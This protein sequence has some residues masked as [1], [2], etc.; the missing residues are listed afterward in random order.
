MPVTRLYYK[1]EGPSCDTKK[2]K[3]LIEDE[4]GR[5]CS[6][7]IRYIEFTR[8]GKMV[9]DNLLFL[10]PRFINHSF[11]HNLNQ[12]EKK[13]LR[14]RQHSSYYQPMQTVLCTSYLAIFVLTSLISME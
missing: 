9:C 6:N 2:N 5:N 3:Q 13:A 4:V 1:E 14:C 11:D 7:A 12:D 8:V 10:C